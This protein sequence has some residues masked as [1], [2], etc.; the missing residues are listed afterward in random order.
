[1]ATCRRTATNENISTYGNATRGYTSLSTWES[2]TDNDL[3]TATQSEV[4]EC[5]DDEDS[6]DDHV[7]LSGATSNSDYFRI[8]RPAIDQGNDGTPNSGFNI[9]NTADFNVFSLGEDY[10]QVQDI[11]VKSTITSSVAHRS[12]FY[13]S[14][15]SNSLIGCIV[16]DSYHAVAE[17]NMQG[18]LLNNASNTIVVDCASINMQS[19]SGTGFGFS[20]QASTSMLMY[21]CISVNNKTF[22]YRSYNTT[23]IAKNCC[24][25][26]NGTDWEVQGSGGFTKTTCTAEGANPTYKDAAGNDFHLASTDTV[27]RDNG[28][29]LSG[30]AT[31]PFDDDI[32][33]ELWGPAWSIGFDQFSA[34]DGIWTANPWAD[35][36]WE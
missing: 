12:G 27:C 17:L 33:G 25:S 28:T 32:D 19:V 15:D 6:F 18:F 36:P 26:G 10:A 35:N 3:V 9:A 4:L 22:G 21:N 34:D 2:A 31:F 23:I 14:G 29:D 7:Y 13:V 11:S 30:D 16:Y 24:A 1:M 5:Y 8:I 20:F